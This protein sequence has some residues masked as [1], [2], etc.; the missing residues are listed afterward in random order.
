MEQ[1]LSEAPVVFGD[2]AV[3]RALAEWLHTHHAEL[4]EAELLKTGGSG[5]KLV[6]AF[7]R[8]SDPRRT[9]GRLIIKLVGQSDDAAVEP[10]NHHAALLSRVKANEDFIDR[11]LV[12]LA[13]IS[14]KF[15]HSWLM[16]QRPAGDGREVT[17]TLAGVG[18]PQRL[19]RLAKEITTGLLS[20]WNPQD[21]EMDNVSA[22]E[23]VRDLLGKRLDEKAPLRTWIR[24]RLGPEAE[25][26]PWFSSADAESVL[27]NP[28]LLTA[29]C[30]L[31]DLRVRFAA[32]GRT[33][34]D[35]HPGN[36]MVPVREDAPADDFTLIDLSRFDERGLLAR[37][38]VHLLLSLV[39][40]AF[41]P[42][43]ETD[44][45]RSELI[46]GLIGTRCDGPLVPQG[47][48]RTVDEVRAAMLDWGAKRHI[49]DGWRHQWHLSL[50]ACALMF[51]ARTRYLDRDRWWFYRLAAEACGAYLDGMSV[52]RPVEAPELR[53][54]LTDEG[55]IAPVTI[56]TVV[57][58]SAG[59]SRSAG[60]DG[61]GTLKLLQEI[62]DT[63]DGPLQHLTVARISEVRGSSLTAVRNRALAF[64]SALGRPGGAPTLS[65]ASREKILKLLH[66]VAV[67]SEFLKNALP[68]LMVLN[69]SNPLTRP[70]ALDQFV[71]VLDELLTV[72]RN[73]TPATSA[74]APS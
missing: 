40:D 10:R 54:Q 55:E 73:T 39:A 20:G 6:S 50:Q 69:L 13:D 58:Q 4:S 14:W 43:L 2:E 59:P 67:R 26:L 57:T 64:R 41:L 22:H 44:E 38:P 74:P 47:L 19:P 1:S 37:D 63:F 23:F 34:G 29:G 27:P 12:E 66:A 71:G 9:G 60:A 3:D 8:E 52:R 16:F 51:T 35:L 53:P 24:A 46:S 36:I 7:V 31:T 68:Q 21:P 18:R 28:V 45:A 49:N 25:S 33:H 15:D 42:H 72:V 32:R 17:D 11:H 65:P 5:G 30:A 62:W 56:R 61:D 70:P 48:A